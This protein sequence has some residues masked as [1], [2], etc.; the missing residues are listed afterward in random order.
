MRVNV[1]I[2]GDDETETTMGIS[3]DGL[4]AWGIFRLLLQGAEM[5][6]Y[7]DVVTDLMHNGATQEEVGYGAP[8]RTRLLALEQMLANDMTPYDWVTFD[9]PAAD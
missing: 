4:D 1:S 9:T 3:A 8:L 7:Q 5:V 2:E 6:V